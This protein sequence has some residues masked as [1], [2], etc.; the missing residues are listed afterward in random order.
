MICSATGKVCFPHKQAAE[1]EAKKIRR[2]S[3]ARGR[4]DERDVLPLV[5]YECTLCRR[6]HLGHRHA[7]GARTVRAEDR[8]R[9][10]Q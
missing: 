10:L 8:K 6:W 7:G 5:P 1:R 2:I 4:R 3:R 9:G